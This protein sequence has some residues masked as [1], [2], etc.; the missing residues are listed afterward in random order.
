[1]H[2][3]KLFLNVRQLQESGCRAGYGIV[4]SGS[5]ANGPFICFGVIGEV[6]PMAC[7]SGMDGPLSI[8]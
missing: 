4:I 2:G 6:Y 7:K 1:L 5:I 3:R 8:A